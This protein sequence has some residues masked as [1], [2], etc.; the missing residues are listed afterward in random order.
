MGTFEMDDLQDRVSSSVNVTGTCVE[1]DTPLTQPGSPNVRGWTYFLRDGDEIKIGFTTR[2]RHRMREHA[3]AIPGVKVLAIVPSQVAGEYETH[4]RFDHLRIDDLER[5][6]AEP[7][8]LD[9]IDRVKAEAAAWIAAHT[10][11]PDPAVTKLLQWRNTHCDDSPIGRRCSNLSEAI[12]NFRKATD[13]AQRANLA[14]SID[15][16]TNDLATLLAA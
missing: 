14:R 1:I 11:P 6:R 16:W 13:P 9:F 7:E 2:P 8:L 4:Q 5:F 15:Q 10:A 12:Q 3:R